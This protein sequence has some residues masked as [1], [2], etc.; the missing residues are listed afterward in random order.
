MLIVIKLSRV[1]VGVKAW[2]YTFTG[3]AILIDNLMYL[4]NINVKASNT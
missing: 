2:K 4:I 3:P 1:N